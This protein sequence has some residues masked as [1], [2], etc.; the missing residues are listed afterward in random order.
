[1]SSRHPQSPPPA[2]DEEFLA[3]VKNL[4]TKT[5]FAAIQNAE[6]ITPIA[7]HRFTGSERVH[8][9]RLDNLPRGLLL[10]GDAACH[11][12]PLF[13]QGMTAAA[14][15]ALTLQKLLGAAVQQTDPLGWLQSN[16]FQ[17]L[18]AILDAPW[19]VAVSD[20]VYPETTGVRPENFAESMK[21]AA[22]LMR[23]AVQ[24]PEVHKLMTEVQQLLKQPS[25]YDQPDLRRRVAQMMV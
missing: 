13:G 17:K 12:N 24:D 11:F 15:E 2:T 18:A 7:R 14:Q 9:E 16:Y 5:I 20:L 8:W 21:F 1:M 10:L 22:A 25:V 3:F 19:S 6:R 4:R 23:L